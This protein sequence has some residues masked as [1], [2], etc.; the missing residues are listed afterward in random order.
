MLD[1]AMDKL[2][3]LDRIRMERD[4]LLRT[5]A[6]LTA[7]DLDTPDVLGEWSIKGVVAHLTFWVRNYLVAMETAARGA[8]PD[9]LPCALSDAEVEVLN[10]R[11]YAAAVPCPPAEIVADFLA[12]N[13][14]L[15]AHVL[16]LPE[17]ALFA[18][19]YY[20]WMDDLTPAQ[21]VTFNSF[22]HYHEHATLIRQWRASRQSAVY[23]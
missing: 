13:D 18:P 15:L 4:F 10:T 16:A 8:R 1:P 3:L 20:S 12:V 5:L 22:E 21:L 19:G 7:D 6:G 17:D 14:G 11:T 23:S 2:R 9:P